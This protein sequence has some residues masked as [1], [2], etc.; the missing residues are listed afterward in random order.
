MPITAWSRNVGFVCARPK[1]V[2]IVLIHGRI[3]R[4][5]HPAN[6]HRSSSQFPLPRRAGVAQHADTEPCGKR[7]PV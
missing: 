1:Y 4:Y 7:S 5:H 3:S 6:F 2:P